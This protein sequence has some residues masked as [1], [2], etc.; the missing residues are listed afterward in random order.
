[1]IDKQIV[2]GHDHR[3]PKKR[4]FERKTVK[5]FVATADNIWRFWFTDGTSFA[6]QS[7]NFSGV[8]CMEICDQCVEAQ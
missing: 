7:E 8:A 2:F 6:I 3:R 5:R 1:M 4:D